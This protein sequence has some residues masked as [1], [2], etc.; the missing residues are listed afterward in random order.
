M[1][2]EVVVDTTDTLHA[3]KMTIE[4]AVGETVIQDTIVM[5][6]AVAVECLEIIGVMFKQVG[7][8]SVSVP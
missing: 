5:I 7:V 2:T 4:E 6:M 1:V 3:V 8:P